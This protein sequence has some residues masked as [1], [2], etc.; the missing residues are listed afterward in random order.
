MRS[1]ADNLLLALGLTGCLAMAPAISATGPSP[2]GGTPASRLAALLGLDPCSDASL[3]KLARGSEALLETAAQQEQQRKAARKEIRDHTGLG[4]L[5]SAKLHGYFHQPGDEL[6]RP[7][8]RGLAELARL[9]RAA[10]A[11]RTPPEREARVA[12]LREVMAALRNHR[13]PPV[14]ERLGL[15]TPLRFLFSDWRRTVG[16]G[17]TRA[18][19]LGPERR[20]PAQRRDGLAEPVAPG[21]RAGAPQDVTK[22]DASR[23]DPAPTS[24]WQRPT[25]I[26]QQ[27][28]Y[29]GFGRERLPSLADAVCRYDGPK[30]SFGTKGG[31][32]VE[33]DGRRYQ[34]KFGEVHSEPFTAR[35]FHALGYHVD[36]TDYAPQLKIR[37]DRRLF[38]E[39][40]LRKPL[41]MRIQ[42]LGLPLGSIALQPRR[43]PFKFIAAAV[44][45]DGRSIPGTELKQILFADPRRRR[46][47]DSPDNFRADIE[48][49]LDYLVLSPANVQPKESHTENIG[50]WTFGGLGHERR[51]ELRG[52]A[53]LAAWL[54]WSDSRYENT[55]LR[56]ARTAGHPEL[57]HFFSDLGAGLGGPSGWFSLHG[58]DPNQ[59]GWAFTRPEIV[60]GPGRM[61]TPFRVAPYHPIVATP[62]FREM[63]LDDA[64]WMARL[65]GQLTEDQIRAALIASGYDAAEVNLYLEKLV[66]RRDQMVR[67]LK[68]ADEIPRLRPNAPDRQFSYDPTVDGPVGVVLASGETVNARPSAQ[69][70][71]RGRLMKRRP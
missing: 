63:T 13:R 42:P 44:F 22:D 50:P 68:L 5:P 33:C 37:Y 53:L 20:P 45:K 17:T 6:S 41:T 9:A 69:T 12:D 30:T 51:R 66:S 29:A 43:D 25:D 60:R 38:R 58:E 57:Q 3:G 24:F 32:D 56:V 1:F 36:P 27:D 48:A 46:P 8:V 34:I 64:R 52:V 49:A 61:T 26:A 2:A 47:E 16:R 39:F 21:R 23:R 11:S 4:N 10:L 55:R 67:D 19:N 62:A 15:A 65:I 28:L 35:V 14:P 40:N 18:S 71:S 59:F 31:F 70:V 54:E 7:E